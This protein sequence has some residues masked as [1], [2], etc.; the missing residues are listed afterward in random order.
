MPD[1]PQ[2]DTARLATAVE[3][4][5]NHRYIRLH[6]S[7]VKMLAY[8]FARG[9][10]FGLGTVIGGGVLVS[11]LVLFLAQFEVIPILGDWTTRLI[12][13]IQPDFT[14]TR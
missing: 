3:K 10:A 5:L 8:Q 12:N 2:N 6:D 1:N 13:E 11:A 14:S 9:L 4:L 7:P